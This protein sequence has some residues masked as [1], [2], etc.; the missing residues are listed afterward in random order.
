MIKYMLFSLLQYIQNGNVIHMIEVTV[1]INMYGDLCLTEQHK[2]LCTDLI[3]GLS[4]CKI[5]FREVDGACIAIT[6]EVFN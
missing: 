4:N 3:I 6:D 1:A 2:E 5:G